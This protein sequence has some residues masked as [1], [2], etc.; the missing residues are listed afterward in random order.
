MADVKERAQQQVLL[1]KAELNGVIQ[2][3]EQGVSFVLGLN[4]QENKTTDSGKTVL[5][6]EGK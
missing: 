1:V 2:G 5:V 6:G 3:Y 4:E